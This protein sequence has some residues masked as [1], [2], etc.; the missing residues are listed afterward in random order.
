M[1]S[2]AI[3]LFSLLI[4]LFTLQI[5]GSIAQEKSNLGHNP[6]A[7]FSEANIANKAS[8]ERQIIPDAYQT[9]Q[10][11]WPQLLTTLDQAPMRFSTAAAENTVA[12]TLPMPDGSF[13]DFQIVNAPVM[14]PGLAAKFPSIRS[15]AGKGIDHP[16]DFLRFSIS[17]HGFHAFIITGK[18]SDIYIDPYSKGNQSYCIAYYKKDYNKKD[19]EPFIC[20][21]EG[22]EITKEE[23]NKT[24]DPSIT[25]PLLDPLAGDCQLRIYR[26]ALACVGEYSAFHG[27]TVAGSLAAMA[28]SMTRIN[29]IYE[30]DFGV[31]MMMVDNNDQLV[32]LNAA[33]DPYTNSSGDLGANQNT[34]DNVIGSANY[35]IGHLLTTSGGGIASLNAPCNNGNKAR[36]LSGQG[37]PVGDPYDVDYVS[38]EM[39]HQF[40][41]NHTQNN[42]CNRN[43]ATAMEPGSASTIMGYA[44]ICNPNVQNNSDDHFHAISIQEIAQ[45]ITVGSGSTCPTTMSTGN[46]QPNIDAGS[47]YILPVSTPFT[48]TAS[49]TDLDGDALTYC[50]EQMDNETAPMP[51]QSTSTQGPAFRS[52]SP[53]DNPARTFPNWN[54][55]INNVDP[56]W[57]ELPSVSRNMDFRCTVRDNSMGNGCTDEDDITLTFVEEA[58]PFLVTNPNTSLTWIV[59]DFANV[60]WDVANTD[61]APVNCAEVDILLSTDGGLTYPIV[62]AENVPNAGNYLSEVPDQVGDQN[63]VMVVCSDNIFF[64]IS[65]QNFQIENPS[66]PGVAINVSPSLQNICPSED[67]LTFTVQLNNLGGFAGTVDLNAT[68]LAAE[69]DFTF[70]PS[71]QVSAPATVEV[72]LNNPEVLNVGNNT[73]TING[74]FGS[75]SSES[76]NTTINLLPD[77]PLT[78]VLDM[79]SNNATT[80]SVNPVLSWA[81]TDFT[82]NYVLEIATNPSFSAGSIV[83]TATV[84]SNSYSPQNLTAFTVYYWRV[85]GI[86]I[87]GASS[88]TEFFSFQTDNPSCLTFDSQDIPV[89]ISANSVGIYTSVVNIPSS[90]IIQDL[91]VDLEVTHSWVGDLIAELRSPSNQMYTLFDSPGSDAANYG[92]GEDNISVTLDDQASNSSN[93]LEMTCEGNGIAIE[94]VFQPLDAFSSLNGEEAQ[95]E[96]ELSVEDIFNQD[97][98]TID[99]WSIEVC[100]AQSSSSDV[101]LTNQPLAL[102]QGQTATIDN[103]LLHATSVGSTEEQMVFTIISLPEHGVLTLNGMPVMVG[104][105]FTQ[106]DIDNG[107]L[108]Y[109][110]DN[111][112]TTEDSF[113]FEVLN[114]DGQWSNSNTFSIVIFDE[115]I[116]SA[117]AVISGTPS[118]VDASDAFV[119]INGFGGTPPYLY[120]INGV[121]FQMSNMFT[122]LSAGNYIFTIQDAASSNAITSEIEITDPEAITITA[123]VVDDNITAIGDGGTGALQYSIDGNIFQDSPN[124]SDLAN[125]DYIVSVIDENECIATTMVTIAVNTLSVII[126]LENN[127]NC[128]GA[129]DGTI[130]L[131]VSGGTPPFQYSIDGSTFQD[132]N[133]FSDLPPGGY[134]ITVLDAEGFTLMSS[135]LTLSNPSILFVN[136][137]VDGNNLTVNANGGTGTVMYSIDGINFQT[138]NM[139]N[140]LES[141]DYTVTVQDQNGCMAN[142]DVSIQFTST[143]D[144]ATNISFSVQPNPNRGY[145]TV[146]LTQKENQAISITVHDMVGRLLME[147]YIGAA[148]TSFQRDIDAQQLSSGVYLL[149]VSN[150][151]SK[152]SKRI[153]IFK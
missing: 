111:S 5:N 50:W 60:N 44:G 25:P 24:A 123:N 38:H 135:Q 78:S 115:G 151:Q 72:T 118:C 51:P 105:T 141:G 7:T 99:A 31:T 85:Q 89:D 92:C 147:E 23:V 9:V 26:L 96:W 81:A 63:R 2:F 68:G 53:I 16:E 36:G 91:N 22:K 57:E 48:L 93:D 137:T 97:G 27:G 153:V 58:G 94:G 40:G 79:P 49:A 146:A 87:C 66:T 71:N 122:G 43:G 103:S 21:V 143:Q 41:A 73:L 88:N 100:F 133:T 132:S 46:N 52:N 108:T 6:W 61:L 30:K 35:D 67:A 8:L 55:L 130:S 54:D 82:D 75:S 29:G 114:N 124:F 45:N 138:S 107:L 12:L 11:D 90:L 127:I 10:L 70:S 131:S 95:G 117:S 64:D 84:E 129:N 20:E 120:S 32:F 121:D 39:G 148:G 104:T 15:F 3:R 140:G 4:C 119:T 14:Q 106:S 83:E 149:S 116:L 112:T 152:I 47:D 74:L 142:T 98:G 18:G 134:M 56:E 101:L 145:F 59:G 77:S 62:L 19:I 17:Q 76:V 109:A 150:D 125:G 1:N 128:F 37:A 136:T 65:N 139:F 110:H 13:A 86:N 69:A 102:P 80:I 144:L 126:N 34:C 33:T 113:L 42:P 28:T